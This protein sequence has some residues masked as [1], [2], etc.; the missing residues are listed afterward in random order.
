MLRQ[1]GCNPIAMEDFAPGGSPPLQRCVQE[2]RACDAYVGIFA[3]RYGYVPE[4]H[5][6]SI[7]ELEY[8]AALAAGLEVFIFLIDEDSHSPDDEIGTRFEA[9]RDLRAKLMKNHVVAFFRGANDLAPKV[10]TSVAKWLAGSRREDRSPSVPGLL[11]YLSDRDR[12]VLEVFRLLEQRS[13]GQRRPTFILMH[14]G[15]EQAHDTFVDRL[16]HQELPR[17][18]RLDPTTERVTHLPLRWRGGGT[19][20]DRLDSLE[21]QLAQA[22]ASPSLEVQAPSTLGSEWREIASAGSGVLLITS[23]IGSHEWHHDEEDLIDS[24]MGL[25]RGFPDLAPARYIVVIV[26]VQYRSSPESGWLFRRRS[27]RQH[28]EIRRSLRALTARGMDRLVVGLLPELSSVTEGDVEEWMKDRVPEFCEATGRDPV[29]IREHL[30]PKVRDLFRDTR[31]PIPMATL[32]PQLRMLL[33]E[34]GKKI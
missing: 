15:L 34:E 30:L 13:A 3:W 17:L 11:P 4:G 25:W 29:L 5:E 28:A 10:V 26:G 20:T 24:W 33:A 22:L 16:I 14:G 9:V 8:E 18:L 31:A 7:T 23:M 1:L 21:L 6:K 12:Q 2:V 27:R 32:G 19:R